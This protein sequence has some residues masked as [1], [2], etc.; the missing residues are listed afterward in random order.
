MFIVGKQKFPE[1][2]NINGVS[3]QVDKNDK[4]YVVRRVHI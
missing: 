2:P 4:K 3:G 1:A